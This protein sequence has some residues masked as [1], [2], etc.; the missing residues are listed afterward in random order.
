MCCL[1]CVWA[2]YP[3]MTHIHILFMLMTFLNKQKCSLRCVRLVERQNRQS[4]LNYHACCF[5]C[6]SYGHTAHCCIRLSY[7]FPNLLNLHCSLRRCL[8]PS[9][10]TIII[11]T[12]IIQ[13]ESHCSVL[14]NI[15]ICLLRTIISWRS[16]PQRDR[17]KIN[18]CVVVPCSG[19]RLSQSNTATDV[20]CRCCRH[21]DRL[22]CYFFLCS[23]F[24]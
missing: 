11:L 23:V 18:C 12:I 4:V 17:L 16:R 9:R 20:C 5:S 3:F 6:R 22:I 7:V 2:S 13:W 1:L 8:N 19:R 15:L 10:F 24:I 14:I 21:N